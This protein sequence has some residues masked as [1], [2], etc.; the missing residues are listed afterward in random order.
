M[1]SLMK[2]MSIALIFIRVKDQNIFSRLFKMM[3]TINNLKS[4]ESSNM[5][6]KQDMN[7]SFSITNLM[8]IDHF[9]NLQQFYA[10]V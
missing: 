4:K 7:V 5:L 6:I 9:S 3:L 2:V 10:F 8:K 1:N